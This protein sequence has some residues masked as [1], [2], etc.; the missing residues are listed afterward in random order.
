MKSHAFTLIELLV[1]VLIIGIV[2]AIALPQ[3]Q[4]AVERARFGTMLPL[5]RAITEAQYVY[6]M[7]N[8]NVANT[9]EELDIGLPGN[10]TI[11]NDSGYRQK[12][13]MKDFNLYLASTATDR[14]MG[15]MTFSDGSVL[16]LYMSVDRLG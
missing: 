15:E 5:L 13:A 16:Q 8:G 9:F 2:S 11:T 10:P 1:V 14:P 4:K 7:A 6:K 12:A 3:Y